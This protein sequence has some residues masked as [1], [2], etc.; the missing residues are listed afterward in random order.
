VNG[1]PEAFNFLLRHRSRLSDD[2]RNWQTDRNRVHEIISRL[3]ADWGQVIRAVEWDQQAAVRILGFLLPAAPEYIGGERGPEPVRVQ[4][5]GEHRYW[6][7]ILNEE[8]EDEPRD[9]EVICDTDAWMTSRNPAPLFGGLMSGDEYCAV[10]ERLAP[11]LV[12]SDEAT[13]L[14]LSEQM[15]EGYLQPTGARLI[16][17]QVDGEIGGGI[18]PDAAFTAIWR[19]ANRRVRPS[20]TSQNWAERQ[21]RRSM[22]VSLSLMNDIYYWASP[23]AGVITLEARQRI[24]GLVYELARETFR[25]DADLIRVSSVSAV[26]LVPPHLPSRG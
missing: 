22:P 2:P 25:T 18:Y 12:S 6:Q 10:W 8:V 19:F 7:R 16:A 17:S 11:S 5:I 21:I 9:Q 1:Y 26:R 23:N 24:R 15:L 20:D 4:G 13:V 3:T 14:Q